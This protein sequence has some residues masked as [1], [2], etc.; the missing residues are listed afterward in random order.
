MT[1]QKESLARVRAGL[2]RRVASLGARVGDHLAAFVGRPGKMIRARFAL[3][4]SGALGVESRLAEG[5][6]VVVELLHNA[7]LLHDDCVDSAGLRRGEPTPN[8][9]FGDTAGI[10]LGDLAFAEGLDAAF[11]ISPAAARLLVDT[12]RDMSVGELQEE[13]LRGSLNVSVE[14]Y[15][16]IAA[17]KTAA[18]FEWCGSALSGLGAAPHRGGDPAR[19]G[20]LAG[21][22]LQIVDDIHD[23]TLDRD[24]A[25]KEPGQDFI[26]GKMTLPCIL[27]MD[28]PAARPRFMELWNR[29]PRDRSTVAE[30]LALL[31]S[32]GCL[33]DARARC[34]GIAAEAAGIVSGLP[35]RE[36]ARA[37][38]EFVEAMAGREF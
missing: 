18:L 22:L 16:G 19:L 25:G 31:E 26:L 30:L 11:E 13:F 12:A 32:S 24:T 21:M 7:S 14:G 28:D 8:S 17:R 38:G 27:A 29:V 20:R 36:E 1:A 23:L 6:G 37:L 3:H 35:V 9:L 10:L 4:L 34:R 5:I 2:D 15:C 33:E